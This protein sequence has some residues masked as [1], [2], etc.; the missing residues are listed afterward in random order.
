MTWQSHISSD[1]GTTLQDQIWTGPYHLFLE[2]RSCMA[3]FA[4][5]RVVLSFLR[6]FW[7]FI[8][9]WFEY[10][11]FT[12]SVRNCDWPDNALL[13]VRHFCLSF[14]LVVLPRLISI[15]VWSQCAR[16]C[17]ANPCSPC[18]RPTDR[19]PT[20]ISK[21][22]LSLIALDKTHCWPQHA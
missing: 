21:S 19:R 10:G 14:F 17:K 16:S 8:I 22:W 9:I 15:L 4:K 13:A 20:L 6:I 11:I 2:V 7:V 12:S 18:C 3:A 1:I 5:R